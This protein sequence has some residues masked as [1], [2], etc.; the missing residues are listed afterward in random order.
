MG[1]SVSVATG[2]IFIS[3]VVSLAV[4]WDAEDDK[5]KLV[6]EARQDYMNR[7]RELLDTY[8]VFLNVTYNGTLVNI[9]AINN[10]STIIDL[11]YTDVYLNGSH[12]DKILNKVSSPI[13]GDMLNTNIWAPRET[14]NITVN[15]TG[16]PVNIP[17]SVKLNCPNGISIYTTI[18]TIY[19]G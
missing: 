4:V 3:I 11:R 16:N 19:T 5:D 1:V 17:I 15:R 14:A 10:G 12:N 8:L 6:E 2:I 18:E 7:Q 13:K 9:T